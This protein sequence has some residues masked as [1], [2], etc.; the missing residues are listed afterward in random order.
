MSDQILPALDSDVIAIV[1]KDHQDAVVALLIA[2]REHASTWWTILNEMRCRNLLPDWALK[3]G[4]G[5]HPSYD[6]WDADCRASNLAL[7][8]YKGN[9]NALI[10]PSNKFAPHSEQ[11]VIVARESGV[12]L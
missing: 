10:Y 7:L 2:E 12:K 6:K 3:M 8:A 5:S 1:P 4:A 11:S 9:L